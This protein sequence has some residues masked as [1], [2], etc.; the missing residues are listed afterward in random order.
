ML[1]CPEFLTMVSMG[2]LFNL[3]PYGRQF[4]G[5]CLTIALIYFFNMRCVFL[6]R[7]GGAGRVTC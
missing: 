7:I 4:N 2:S 3:Q 6:F 1:P 5:V